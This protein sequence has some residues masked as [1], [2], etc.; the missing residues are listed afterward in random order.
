MSELICR[1]LNSQRFRS[2]FKTE[3]IALIAITMLLTLN[4]CSDKTLPT[5]KSREMPAGLNQ[6]VLEAHGYQALDGMLFLQ[7]SVTVNRSNDSFLTASLLETQWL[8]VVLKYLQNECSK[9]GKPFKSGFENLRLN[10]V[11][12]IRVTKEDNQLTGLWAAEK[13]QI[14]DVRDSFCVF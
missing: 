13:K 4:G 3:V 2:R 14:D 7:A 6:K 12:Q 1:R 9:S 10:G 5:A 8:P 11:R